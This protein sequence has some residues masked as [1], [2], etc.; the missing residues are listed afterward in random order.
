MS[1]RITIR[2]PFLLLFNVNVGKEEENMSTCKLKI[3]DT[4]NSE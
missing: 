3:T 2:V 4:L 1:K